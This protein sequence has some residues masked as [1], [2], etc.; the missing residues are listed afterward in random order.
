MECFENGILTEKDTGGRPL[1]FGDPDAMLWLIEEIAGR[2]GIGDVLALG[3]KRAAQK[4]GRGAEQYAFHIKGQELGFHDGRGKTGMAMG[5]ALSP[6]GADHIE[7]P[8]DV[9]F[10]GD[11]VSKLFPMGLFDPVDPLKTDPAKMRFFFIGQKAWGINNVLNLCNFVSVP[12][13]AMTFGRLV[14]AVNAITGWDVSLYELVNASERS[15]VMARVFNNREGFTPKDDTL[16]S[17]WFEEMPS[18]P[19][20]GKR[21]DPEIFRDLVQLYYDMSGW[22]A[23]GRPTRGKLVELGLYWLLE[24]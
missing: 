6:T 22:D 14:E 17:R 2:R 3:V 1:K 23:Q 11:G 10:Q 21:I 16:I 8:H 13:H 24:N 18:G 9:A 7:T 20:K 4:I 19:L 5:F 15:N 12:I